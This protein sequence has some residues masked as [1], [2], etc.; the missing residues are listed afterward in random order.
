MRLKAIL[1]A[2]LCIVGFTNAA[3]AQQFV[4]LTDENGAPINLANPLTVDASV[5]IPPISTITTITNPVGVKGA[6][7]AAITSSTNPFPIRVSVD[8]TNFMDATHGGWFNILQG[9]SVLD[10]GNPL[11]VTVI[12]GGGFELVGVKG[13]D[14]VTIVSPSNPFDVQITGTPNVGINTAANL[15]TVTGWNGTTIVEPNNNP[16]P[17]MISLDVNGGPINYTNP[18]PITMFGA[19]D[20]SLYS[21]T[22]PIPVKI[23][24]A[25]GDIQNPLP[26]ALVLWDSISTYNLIGP[27]HPMPIQHQDGSGTET[28]MPVVV[29]NTNPVPVAPSG[30]AAA[31]ITNVGG[32]VDDTADTVTFVASSH[33]IKVANNDALHT[34]WVRLDGGTAVAGTSAY[35][36]PPGRELK[37]EGAALPTISIIADT[38]LTADYSV[39]AY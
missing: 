31:D 14:G 5:T 21:S 6:N 4:R 9:N 2:L 10:S 24:G 28:D 18:F 37:Y 19:N 8:G 7:P 22:N 20:A 34:L 11:P 3:M 17:V 27:A 32:T 29:N 36:L 39:L 1:A 35:G 38:G 12:S 30:N 13:T 33:N 26:N 16:F 25:A 15:I 23:F